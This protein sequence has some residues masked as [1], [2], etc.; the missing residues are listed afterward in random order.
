MGR[1]G[2]VWRK[3]APAM[4]AI[5]DPSRSAV[6]QIMMNCDDA[7]TLSTSTSTVVCS[8]N[9]SRCGCEKYK[10]AV[11]GTAVRDTHAGQGFVWARRAP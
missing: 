5:V 6:G 9:N 7:R 11:H 8:F 1:I 4:T 3:C 2:W 10:A